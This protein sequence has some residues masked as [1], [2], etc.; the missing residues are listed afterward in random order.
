MQGKNV[1]FEHRICELE[2][3]SGLT[4]VIRASEGQGQKKI[5]E[6]LI[7]GKPPNSKK[8]RNPQI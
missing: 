5:F 3:T 8:T 6:K 7:A 4:H 1:F 2:A